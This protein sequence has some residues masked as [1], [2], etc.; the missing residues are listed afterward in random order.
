M[1]SFYSKK[2]ATKPT[3]VEILKNTRETLGLDLKKVAA[4]LSL[5]PQYLKALEDGNFKFFPGEIYIKNFIKIYATYLKLNSRELLDGYLESQK[6]FCDKKRNYPLK[7][8]RIWQKIASSIIFLR[9]GLVG[10]VVV[11]LIIYLGYEIFGI[12][13]S[14][15]LTVESPEEGLITTQADLEVKGQTLPETK[16][17][18]NGVEIVS[19]RLGLFQEKIGLN[20]GSNQ[21]FVTALKKYGRSTSL[22]RNV[23]YK[24]K[25]NNLSFNN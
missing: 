19:D 14:P 20:A 2:L 13:Q 7:K 24:E 16:V 1:V 21:I 5:S 4:S 3:V 15:P 10:L 12:F 17:Q 25:K 6:L 23:I 8:K 11:C 9:Q 22:L 18:I